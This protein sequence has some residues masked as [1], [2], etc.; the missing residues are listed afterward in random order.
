MTLAL[1]SDIH[2]NLQALEACLRHARERGATRYAF[3]GDLVGYGADASAVVR[4][5]MDYA[6]RGALVVKGNHDD[7]V[8]RNAGYMNEAAREAIEWARQALAKEEK[9]FLAGLPLCARSGNACFVHASA[10]EPARWV[11]I[12]GQGAAL[13][14]MEA[15]KAPYTFSGHV[16]EQRLYARVAAAR[17][18]SFTPHPGTAIPLGTHRAWLALVGSV[19][20]PRDGST[21]A[22]Y[23]LFDESAARLTYFR[24]PYD[25]AQA[26]RAIRRA[27]L[28][29]S[30]AFRVERGI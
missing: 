1:L 20:Q 7:A 2:A 4:M 22:A 12:D 30:L 24:I 25:Y 9:A 3:L 13:R 23:A 21:A 18:T 8:E 16:H 6:A 19:G 17:A 26:A 29:E 27:G 14:S 11:Y 15:A 28:A 10:S 5:V